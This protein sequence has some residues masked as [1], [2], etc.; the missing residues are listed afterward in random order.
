MPIH[1]LYHEEEINPLDSLFKRLGRPHRQ[2]F[3]VIGDSLVQKFLLPVYFRLAALFGLL[4]IAVDIPDDRGDYQ[5]A[6][7]QIFRALL[8]PV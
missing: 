2:G 5:I 8:I 7:R 6:C 4:S 1:S 3:A